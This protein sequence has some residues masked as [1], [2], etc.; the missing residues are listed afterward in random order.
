MKRVLGRPAPPRVAELLSGEWEALADGVSWS[1]VD[2]TADAS[3]GGSAAD[4]EI[5]GSRLRGVRLTGAT[6]D[7]VRLVDVALDD[8]ELSGVDFQEATFVRVRFFRCRM[9]GVVATALKAEDVVFGECQLT[10]SN[11][12]SSSFQRC[13]FADC[14]LSEADFYAAKLT[15]GVL[16]RCRLTSTEFSKAAC[17]GLDLRGSRV[18]GIKGCDAL[19]GAV[20]G[21]DQMVPLGVA[22]LASLDIRVDDDPRDS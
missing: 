17:N 13:E 10:G 3:F 14:D 8:C 2:A 21:S 22:L 20:I 6:F 11:F 19:R 4:C 9:S 15:H 12:R 16:R 5:V 7:R 18:E 1:E